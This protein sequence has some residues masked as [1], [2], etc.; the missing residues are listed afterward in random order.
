MKQKANILIVDDDPSM[1]RTTA[2]VLGRKGYA[3]EVAEDGPTAIGKVQEA[4]FDLILM[5]I[6]MPLMNGV[7]TY[8]RI[9]ALRPQAAVIMMTAYS[10]ED[11]IQ[12]ALQ[13]GA[14]GVIY[15]PLDIERTV[16]L[17]EQARGERKGALVLVVDDDL[18]TCCTLRQVLQRKGYTVAV[19]HDGEAAIALA[20]EQRYDA[21]LVDMKLPTIN[22]LQTYLAIREIDPQV[23]AVVMTGY[24]QEMDDLVQ[25]ALQNHACACLYK[26]LDLDELLRLLEEVVK[27][28]A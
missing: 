5:D 4:P 3:V 21:I 2:L 13:E 8:K 23:V 17:I 14:C 22:G 19:A 16:A 1:S 15:K 9:K 20:R 24:R 25:A 26:P 10:V 7:E 6:K 12:E 27:R 11:L 28:Q 18:S